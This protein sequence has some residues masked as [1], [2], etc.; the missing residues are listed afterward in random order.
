MG[1]PGVKCNVCW[2]ASNTTLSEV[3]PLINMINHGQW[4]PWNSYGLSILL[5]CD[6]R[7]VVW[8]PIKFNPPE[9]LT[10]P[11]GPWN[12][13]FKPYFYYQT[14]NTQKAQKINHWLSFSLWRDNPSKSKNKNVNW[15]ANPPP[16]SNQPIRSQTPMAQPVKLQKWSNSFQS[17]KP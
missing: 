11:K 17:T 16:P 6:I 13:N 12:Q 5:S 7:K 14:C 9:L 8:I 15:V 1:V 3:N 4:V 10:D 2:W